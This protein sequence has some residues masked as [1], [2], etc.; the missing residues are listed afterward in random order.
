MKKYLKNEPI[1]EQTTEETKILAASSLR[2]DPL[3][4]ENKALLQS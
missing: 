2:D 4:S 1:V 3:D